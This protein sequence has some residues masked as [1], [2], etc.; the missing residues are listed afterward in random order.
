MYGGRPVSCSESPSKL[1]ALARACSSRFQA[2]PGGQPWPVHAAVLPG[3]RPESCPESMPPSD[4]VLR[5]ACA[6]AVQGRSRPP[7]GRAC[8]G[9]TRTCSCRSS[10]ATVRAPAARLHAH[11]CSGPCAHERALTGHRWSLAMVM[12][13]RAPELFRDAGCLLM[14]WPARTQLQQHGLADLHPNSMHGS[15]Q[16]RH[17]CC[18]QRTPACF[19]CATRQPAG[20]LLIGQTL[21]CT[22]SAR[23][24]VAAAWRSQLQQFYAEPALPTRSG[25]LLQR[26]WV[27]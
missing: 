6:L 19:T 17:A 21:D 9:S 2:C 27:S 23:L 5:Q 10:T 15:A 7:Q 20:Q 14:H 12:A 13:G 1:S 25:H 11:A 22:R 16:S 8:G 24:T 18:A 26:P 4:G 3:P